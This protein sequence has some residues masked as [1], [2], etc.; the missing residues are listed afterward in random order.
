MLR[1]YSDLTFVEIAEIMGTPL[2][3]ALARSHRALSKL[4]R[5]MEEPS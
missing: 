2:G 4:R 3:T 1:H 5:Y